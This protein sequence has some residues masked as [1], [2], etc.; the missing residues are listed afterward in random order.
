MNNKTVNIILLAAF[1]LPVILI[2]WPFAQWND[3]MSLFLRVIPAISVQLL[4]CRTTRREFIKT[5]P[6]VITAAAALWGSYL[7]C[8]SPSW[9]NATLG[10]LIADYISMFICCI[11]VYIIYKVK[12]KI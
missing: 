2:F 5:T 9:S 6:I 10:G 4:V 7:Y 1:L 3:G 12:E 8:T 11:T